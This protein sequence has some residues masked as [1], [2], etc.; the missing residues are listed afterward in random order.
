MNVTAA[1]ATGL[2][3]ASSTLTCSGSGIAAADARRSALQRDRDD[4]RR[5]ARGG[6]GQRERDRAVLRARGDG[7]AAG[8]AVGG[9][10]RRGDAARGVGADRDGVRPAGGE[11]PLAP[12]AGALN[13][14]GTPAA[15]LVTGQ[16]SLLVSATCSPLAKAL[17]R[18]AVC[19]VP[20]T[21]VSWFGG[22]EDGQFDV[23]VP[24]GSGWRSAGFPRGERRATDE[25]A[26]RGAQARGHD[27]SERRLCAHRPRAT[28]RSRS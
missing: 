3:P 24:V 12:P 20:A 23:P 5:Y 9:E 18:I 1:P 26:N 6:V 16:P 22:L 7:V 28:A 19:G 27:Q 8:G 14:T 21:S 10:R 25:H 2:P 13:V 17:C 15:A 4:P 11:H